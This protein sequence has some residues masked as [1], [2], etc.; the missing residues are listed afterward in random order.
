MNCS[1][2]GNNTSV[3]VY[4]SPTGRNMAVLLFKY[5]AAGTDPYPTIAISEGR[6]VSIT[7]P[8]V[9]DV[10]LERYE[11]RSVPG[12]VSVDHHIGRV[13]YPVANERTSE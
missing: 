1:K 2:I 12:T 5:G 6:S 4:I 9:S 7:V 11:W 3:S 10:I 13:M 8:V